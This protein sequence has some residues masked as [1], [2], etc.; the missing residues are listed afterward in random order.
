MERGLRVV[1]KVTQKGLEKIL[2]QGVEKPHNLGD[3]LYL[4]INGKSRDFSFRYTRN[5]ITR[6]YSLKPYH[7]KTNTLA[8]ARKRATELSTMLA[9]G[10][11]PHEEKQRKIDLQVE[12]KQQKMAEDQIKANTFAIVAENYM[13]SRRLKWASKTAQSWENTL[14]TYAYPVIGDVAVVD[15]S[16]FDIEK[17]LKPIW[18]SKPDLSTKLLQRIRRVFS[19]AIYLGLIKSNPAIH[20]DNLEDALDFRDK[21]KVKH[22]NAL[23]YKLLPDFMSELL[24][25]NG[26]A[27]K[28]L[29]FCVLN[30][31]RTSEALGARWEE[32]DMDKAIW[33]IPF[34]RLSIKND[35]DHEI[36][37][38]DQSLQFLA[39]MK[40]I[41]SGPH[42]FANPNT[43]KPLSNG[44][45]LMLIRRMGYSGKITVHGFRSSF[46]DF[47]AE[48]AEFANIV[49]EMALAHSIKSASERAYRRG[50]LLKRRTKM[51]QFY[52]DYVMG[53]DSGVGKILDFNQK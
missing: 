35:D 29:Q 24:Q 44:A 27:A 40:N 11:D 38:T 47:I 7:A 26:M 39:K 45:M 14:K 37:L 28:A 42:V 31:T 46:R 17:I 32:F 33:T 52:A 18:I 9:Q 8:D 4:V 15:I 49:A 41:Q 53:I 23:D 12:A 22:W 21:P 43:G 16:K 2:R 6:K 3:K 34:D 25:K 48:E 19:R 30:A 50:K 10:L 1:D 20:R 51:M 36:P 13:A 5:K